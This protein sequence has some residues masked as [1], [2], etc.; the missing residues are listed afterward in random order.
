[1]ADHNSAADG[2]RL[3]GKKTLGASGAA[4]TRRVLSGSKPWRE[5]ST[6]QSQ[7]SSQKKMVGDDFGEDV[8]KTRLYFVGKF[9]EASC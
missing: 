3:A 8:R 4:G 5:S 6:L 7:G 2:S 9:M 1:M